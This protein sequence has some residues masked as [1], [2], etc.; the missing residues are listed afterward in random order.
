MTE[1]LIICCFVFR[2]S[3]PPADNLYVAPPYIGGEIFAPKPFLIE[4]FNLFIIQL[5]GTNLIVLSFAS[6]QYLSGHKGCR[7]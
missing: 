4:I 1:E 6:L 7:K 2:G 5:F 3:Q